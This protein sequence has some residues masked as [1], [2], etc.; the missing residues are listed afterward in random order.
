MTTSHQWA[1]F[2]IG[3]RVQVSDQCYNQPLRGAV[4]IVAAP[5][6]VVVDHDPS[7]QSSHWRPDASGD[8]SRVYWIEFTSMVPGDDPGHPIDAAEIE[9]ADLDLVE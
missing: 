3:D 1:R 6:A 4:G 8:K 2:N 5:P 9:E 7:W